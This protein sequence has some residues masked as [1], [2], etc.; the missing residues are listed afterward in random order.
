MQ[1]GPNLGIQAPLSFSAKGGGAPPVAQTHLFIVAGQS[2]AA[3][4]APDDGGPYF[5]LGSLEY[6]AGNT[7]S[8]VGKRLYHGPWEASD[9]TVANFGFTRQ[10][11]ID[12]AAAHPGVTLGFIGVAKG[13]T[14]FYFNN[15][16]KGNPE[17]SQ[18]IARINAA[19]AVQPAGAQLK[20][21]LWHQG[22]NDGQDSTAQNA[23]AAA[24]TQFIS[25]FRADIAGGA[26]LPFVLGGHAYGAQ[27]YNHITHSAIQAIPN[28]IL[29]TGYAPADIPRNATLADAIHYDAISQRALG[30][31]FV[32]ALTE[33]EAN[34]SLGG[35][36]SITVG[37]IVRGTLGAGNSQT[38]TG[39]SLGTP[40][41][42]RLM[43][44]GLQGR[45]SSFGAYPQSV[46]LGGIG[47]KRVASPNTGNGRNGTTLFY[48]KIPTGTTGD[49]VITWNAATVTA[50]AGY[51]VLP[52]YGARA[53]LARQGGFNMQGGGN[54][55]GTTISSD[56]TVGAGDLVLALC[57]AQQTAAPVAT[58]DLAV[59]DNA[60]LGPNVTMALGY[61]IAATP[62]QRTV[63]GSFG[64][65]TVNN[66]GLTVMTLRPS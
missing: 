47:L 23:Y 64:G 26:N 60:A 6:G 46:T 15:W 1:I 5:P 17:Y 66:P 54:G 39:L 62:G 28:T 63:T 59:S 40:A 4:R 48:A 29:R 12:Y 2:N 49:L 43:I 7:W 61:E 42:D 53:H 27:Y 37:A 3:G 10:F 55:Y 22:E 11:A 45:N 19:L 41:T 35:S 56:L 58:L 51:V 33:A 38:V 13:G 50:Q 14:G 52:V 34:T 18:A 30:S 8:A 16:N 9:A 31:R 57:G 20:G 25:D 44:V 36:A 32:T 65:V 24:L 21:I